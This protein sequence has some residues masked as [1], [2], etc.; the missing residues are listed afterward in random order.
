VRASAA[1]GVVAA[2]AAGG[3]RCRVLRSA[4]P[5]TFRETSAGLTWIGSAAGPV[6]GD[7]LE[8][9]LGLEPG[10]SLAVGSVAASLVHPGPGGETSMTRIAATVGSRARLR[11]SPHPTVL[12]RGCD[13]STLVE[14][15]LAEDAAL[16]WRDEVVLGR[17]G[18]PSGSLRQRVTVDR[19]RRPLLRSELRL[20]PRWPGANGPAGAAGA[21]AIGSVLLVGVTAPRVPPG[22]GLR[23]ALHQLAAEAWS[24]HVLGDRPGE[25][26]RFLD[27]FIGQAAAGDRHPDRAFHRPFARR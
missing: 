13:H 24:L 25:V 8:L 1:I 2:G 6:G 17:H 18:E 21:R 27:G 14:V 11:W 19:G 12:V 3:S 7:D 16:V 4:P 23:F 22:P 26:T 20:G 5:L 10:T 15:D 9:S